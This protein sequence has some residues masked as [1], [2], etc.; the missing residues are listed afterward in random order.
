MVGTRK[1]R[2]VVLRENRAGDSS[3][4]GKIEKAYLIWYLIDED[5]WQKCSR[6]CNSLCKG[7]V[8]ARVEEDTLT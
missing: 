2:F 6:K 8:W 4:S 7:P 1:E 3:Q 5:R